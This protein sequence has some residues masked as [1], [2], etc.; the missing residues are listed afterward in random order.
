MNPRVNPNKPS[1]LTSFPNAVL[2]ALSTTKSD[3]KCRLKISYLITELNP[4]KIGL[5]DA[6][7]RK[8]CLLVLNQERSL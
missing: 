4:Y 1:P 3:L 7:Q 5:S 6:V 2:Q 8:S